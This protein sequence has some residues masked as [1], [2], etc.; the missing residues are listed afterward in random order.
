[1]KKL[2]L[3]HFILLIILYGCNNAVIFDDNKNIDRQIKKYINEYK[4]I[5]CNKRNNYVITIQRKT[6]GDTIEYLI[7]ADNSI[8]V[9]KNKNVHY[10]KKDRDMFI[11]TNYKNSCFKDSLDLYD[12][13][14]YLDKD[15]YDYFLKNKQIPPPFVIGYVLSMKLIFIKDSLLMKTYYYF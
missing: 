11:F 10:F 4:T 8:S 2:F 15:E 6:S 12:A 7:Q 14:K 9:F 1:M 3:C 13:M 5:T